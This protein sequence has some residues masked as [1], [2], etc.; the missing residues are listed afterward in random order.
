MFNTV[1]QGFLRTNNAVEGWR[2]A[3]NFALEASYNVIVWKF[4]NMIKRE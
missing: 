4:I 3:F 2:T 1:M